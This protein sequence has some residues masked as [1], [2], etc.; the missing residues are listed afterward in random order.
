MRDEGVWLVVIGGQ[1]P[2]S[3]PHRPLHHA[4]N[5]LIVRW[6]RSLDYSQ[7]VNE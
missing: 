1:S 2:Q 3:R 5:L 6:K 4:S 7:I